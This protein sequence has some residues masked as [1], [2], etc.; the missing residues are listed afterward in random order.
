MLRDFFRRAR[1]AVVGGKPLDDDFYEELEDELIRA[2]VG[3]ETTARLVEGVRA[4]ADADRTTDSEVVRGL[5]R[6]AVTELL[7]GHAGELNLA[8]SGP[9]VVLVVGVNGTGKTTFCARL[10]YRLQRE[11]KKVLLAAGDT[12]R[13]AAIEQLEIWADRIGCDIVRQQPGGDPGAVLFDAIEAAKARGVDVVVADTAGRIHTKANLMEELKK[14]GRVV[15]RALGA[16]PH[17][18]LLVLDATTGQNAVRQAK[19]FCQAVPVTG[20]VVAK[21][22]GTAKGGVMI[23]VADELNLPIK[24]LGTGERPRDLVDFQPRAF[25][26]SLFDEG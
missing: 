20:L 1:Q 8:E 15:E 16:P 12:F 14:I 2:D 10:A 23:T 24:F 21:T 9:T 25:A 18:V 13:A 11:G 26:A 6:D 4:Q 19:L 5:L 3:A 7:E 22:D 17:E